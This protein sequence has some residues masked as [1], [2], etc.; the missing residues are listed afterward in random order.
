M[1]L[2]FGFFGDGK[3]PIFFDENMM[4]RIGVI[5]EMKLWFIRENGRNQ[6]FWNQIC[7]IGEDEIRLS[8]LF[9]VLSLPK[10]NFDS[11]TIRYYYFFSPFLLFI[12]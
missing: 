9:E 2:R 12:N 10:K 8:P 4:R 1:L 6:F 3:F 11:Y 5:D 7:R